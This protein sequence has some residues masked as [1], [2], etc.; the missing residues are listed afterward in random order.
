MRYQSMSEVKKLFRALSILLSEMG[1]CVWL[2]KKNS[3]ERQSIGWFS[4]RSFMKTPRSSRRRATLCGRAPGP[5]EFSLAGAVQHGAST[6]PEEAFDHFP[7]LDCAEI[8]P[9]TGFQN[10]LYDNP[11]FPQE[12]NK[13][14]Y[15]FLGKEFA[16]EKKE[17]ETKE[18]FIYKT[19]KKGF[20]PL[21]EKFWSLPEAFRKEIGKELEARFEF[22]FKKLNAVN[23]VSLVRKTVPLDGEELRVA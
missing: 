5:L 1:R 18:Q 2:T 6:L 16:A 4:T 7:R 8:H 3:A 19:R 14:I 15:D 20:G 21:K 13:E 17:A 23:T 10:M 12:V 22:L 9:A 11:G